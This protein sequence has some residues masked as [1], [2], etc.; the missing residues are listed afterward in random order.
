MAQVVKRHNGTLTA[1][2]TY[3]NPVAI[4]DLVF[5]SYTL[6]DPRIRLQ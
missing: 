2:V 6:A 3:N 4:P 5:A 1:D